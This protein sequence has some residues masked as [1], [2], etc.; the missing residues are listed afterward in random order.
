[1]NE[2]LSIPTFQPEWHAASWIVG[3]LGSV[4][5]IVIYAGVTLSETGSLL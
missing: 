4:L 3:T 5:W 1:M 2:K